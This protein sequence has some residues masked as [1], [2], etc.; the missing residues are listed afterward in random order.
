M[1]VEMD[2]V[3]N[4]GRAGGLLDDPVGPL[5]QNNQHS[6]QKRSGRGRGK[7]EGKGGEGETNLVGLRDTNSVVQSR[8]RLI[9]LD[10][11]KSRLRPI[12]P[13]RAPLHRP[14]HKILPIH[15]NRSKRHR[16]VLS[17]SSEL[18]ARDIEGNNRRGNGIETGGRSS[19]ERRGRWVYG[20]SA[21]VAEN[22]ATDARVR[23]LADCYGFGA[24]PVV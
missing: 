2:W 4:G 1:A 17:L 6:I 11:L 18:R 14:K 23:G 21:R 8:K 20:G 19:G 13:H 9:I 7:G 10:I 5:S 3:G 12:N 15:G 16:Q 24:E 22:R